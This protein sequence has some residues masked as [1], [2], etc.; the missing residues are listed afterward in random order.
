M[1]LSDRM[2]TEAQATLTLLNERGG[3]LR[4]LPDARKAFILVYAAQGEIDNGGLENFFEAPWPSRP[5]YGEFAAAYRAIGAEAE[6]AC[7]EEAI[8]LFA[9]PDPHL[10]DA[11]RMADL[12]RQEKAGSFSRLNPRLQGN[13]GVWHRLEAFLEQGIPG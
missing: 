2:I 9:I 7:L 4:A 5:A 1:R 10:D 12:L 11:G 6:A 3:E 13:E 8:A